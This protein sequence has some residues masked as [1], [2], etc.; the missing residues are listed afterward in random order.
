MTFIATN[1]ALPKGKKFYSISDYV[2][3]IENKKKTLLRDVNRLNKLQD[4]TEFMKMQDDLLMK[5]KFYEEKTTIPE[6]A[7]VFTE[8]YDQRVT[9]ARTRKDILDIIYEIRYLNFLPCCK[10]KLKDYS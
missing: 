6:L 10:F 3:F 7:Q 5:I 1:N 8:L 9:K 2:D 4:P